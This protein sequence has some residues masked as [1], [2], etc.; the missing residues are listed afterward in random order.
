MA[1]TK[2]KALIS[3]ADAKRYLG[4]DD[5]DTDDD[6]LI[7]ICVLQASVM[8][9]QELGCDILDTVYTKEL[10]DGDGGPYLYLNNWPLIEVRRAAIGRDDALRVTYAGTGSHARVLVNN[11]EVRIRYAEDGTWTDTG[12][13]LSDYA[14]VDALATAIT[15]VSG[16]TGTALDNFDD[17]PASELLR[18]PAKDANGENVDC[19]VAETSE[20]D[21]EIEDM[22]RALLYNPRYWSSG[23][24][25]VCVDY[26]A[27]YAREDLPEP[28]QAAA[29]ELTAMLWNLSKK[30]PT[31]RS[32]KIGA[33]SYTVADR[34]DAIFSASGETSVSNMLGPKIDNYRRLLLWGAMG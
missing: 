31:L 11:T 17:Y 28:L 13:A 20:T 16:W 3:L 29:A 25:N 9:R 7:D 14:T 23:H 18:A 27:G 33:Y 26:R 6:R 34:L 21:Y 30:D 12:F 5:D 15:A 32:E 4:K 19:E 2:T 1:T 10:H 8:I 24:G 22:D